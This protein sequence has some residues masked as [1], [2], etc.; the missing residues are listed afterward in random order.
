MRLREILRVGVASSEL[1]SLVACGGLKVKNDIPASSDLNA[2][3]I[4]VVSPG[5]GENFKVGEP[6][7]ITWDYRNVDYCLFGYSFGPGSLNRI[8][9]TRAQL[10][11]PPLESK[12]MIWRV[13]IGN[14]LANQNKQAK[15]VITCYK[16]GV[17]SVEDQSED[18]FTVSS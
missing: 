1:A 2:P 18:F 4:K 3:Y 14:I 12:K 7:D 5:G 11:Y 16:M 9:V 13:D 10:Q 15:V 8:S 17:G 6:V